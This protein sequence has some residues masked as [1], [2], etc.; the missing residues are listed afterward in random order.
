MENYEKNTFNTSSVNAY[1]D[2]KP[3]LEYSWLSRNLNRKNIEFSFI[4]HVYGDDVWG[5]FKVLTPK[6]LNSTFY[7][8]Y[9]PE[10]YLT[11][12]GGYWQLPNGLP[13]GFNSIYTGVGGSE[14]VGKFNPNDTLTQ[15]DPHHVNI[16]MF[17]EDDELIED[18]FMDV[19]MAP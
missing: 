17:W 1:L 10:E 9:F 16:D 11:D 14:S 18:W 6:Y 5:D 8:Y 7:Q 13:D 2:T 19:E 4:S 15:P 12:S 3:D